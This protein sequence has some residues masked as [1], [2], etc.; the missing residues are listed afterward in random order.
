MTGRRRKKTKIE[1]QWSWRTIEM[2]ESPAFR[3]L[4]LSEHRFLDR[5]EIELARHGGTGNGSLPVTF[6]QFEDHNIN[7]KSIPAAKRVVSALGF[8]EVTKQGRGGNAE[9]RECSNY[10]LTYKPTD[11]ENPTNEWR[12]IAKNI[13]KDEDALAEAERIADA[14]RKARDPSAV[15]RSKRNAG[16][17]KGPS[18]GCKKYP[19]KR[20]VSGGKT[21]PSGPGYKTHPT[22]Y[23]SGGVTEQSGCEARPLQGAVASSPTTRDRTDIVQDRVAHRLRAHGGWSVMMEMPD[24]E[25]D[26]LVELERA[27]HLRDEDLQAALSRIRRGAA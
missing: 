10:R 13:E 5:L 26:R 1:G 2:M 16:V 24:A 19:E 17:Q 25:I 18:S 12:E 27:G 23:I 7:R 15:A 20:D 21:A 8:V 4:N 22:I 6:Q 11:R 9:Y 3:V 14:A